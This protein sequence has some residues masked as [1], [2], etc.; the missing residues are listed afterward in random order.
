MRNGLYHGLRAG[1]FMTVLVIVLF[2]ASYSAYAYLAPQD[3]E[4]P[5]PLGQK[6]DTATDI[7][8]KINQFWCSSSTPVPTADNKYRCEETTANELLCKH[9]LNPATDFYTCTYFGLNPRIGSSYYSGVLFDNCTHSI[10]P[11]NVS[12]GAA[13]STITAGDSTTLSWTVAN[14]TSCT[15]SWAGSIAATSGSQSVTPPSTTTYS[16]TCTGP[17][18]TTGPVSTTVTV[19][20]PPDTTAPTDPTGLSTSAVST[21]Q[22]NLLWTGSTDSGG[23][24]LAGYRI[25]RCSGSGCTGFVQVALSAAASYSD[26][27]LAP[28]TSYTYRVRAYDNALPANIS[29]YSNTASA[30][31]WTPPD[32]TP[33]TAPF[34]SGTP[35]SSMQ[36]DLSWTASTDSSGISDYRVYRD[37]A[38]IVTLGASSLSYSDVGLMPAT[39]YSYF[40]VARDTV[41]N[42]ANSN[43]VSVLTPPLPRSEERRVGKE[44]RSRWSPYH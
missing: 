41:G 4:G 9:Y 40:V 3:C 34:L 19:N 11:P 22:I 18:G 27:G 32:T 6:F 29:G 37:S 16:L 13:P 25:E 2:S 43:T 42:P 23:S 33:P 28:A 10:V 31:T 38:L 14:A 8:P 7:T 20:P 44:C 5:Y 1:V 15:S 21:S 39:S 35:F 17:G 26:A 30:T 36:I 24:G 12:L